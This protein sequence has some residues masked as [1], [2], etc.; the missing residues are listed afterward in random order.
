MLLLCEGLSAI[1]NLINVRNAKTTGGYPLKGKVQNVHGMRPLE[2]VKNK[3]IAE[4][5]TVIGLYVGM[6]AENLNYGKIVVFSDAD[7]DGSHIYCLL[8][9]LFS[10]WPELFEQKRIYRLLAPLYYCT[11]GK[12][13]KMFYTQEEFEAFD[14][15]GWDVSRYKGL[16]SMPENVY[17]KC[18][19]DPVLEC[20]VDFDKAIMDMAFG[21]ESDARK[22]WLLK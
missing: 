17:E 18:V 22:E 13:E 2:I 4:L 15:K 7:I 16:G 11:K 21:K 9:N 12:Q 10:M 6:P 8:L 19:N 1:G 5:L 20:V 3:E 14:S